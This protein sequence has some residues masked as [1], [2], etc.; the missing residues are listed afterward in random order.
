MIKVIFKVNYKGIDGKE[1]TMD[2]IKASS[3]YEATS[4]VAGIVNNDKNFGY[5]FK[6]E[7]VSC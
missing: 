3:K 1:Y 7:F 5:S 4:I 2:N 6:A